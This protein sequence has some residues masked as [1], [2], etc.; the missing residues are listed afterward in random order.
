MI[1]PNSQSTTPQCVHI[2][3]R[4]PDFDFSQVEKVWLADPFKSHFMNALSILI[5]HSERIV[6]EI[7]RNNL[8]R[9]SDPVL[10]DQVSALIKQEG[11]HAAMHRKSNARLMECYPAISF[12]EKTQ[13]TFMGLVRRFSSSAF[14]LAIPAAFEHFTAAISR[15]VLKNHKKWTSGKSNQSIDFVNWHSLE[16]IEHQAVCYDVYKAMHNSGWRLVL[17]LLCFWMPITV[18]ST[19]GIQLYLLHKDRV[20]YK[21]KNWLPYLKFVGSSIGLFTKGIFQYRHPDFQPWQPADKALYLASLARM[22]ESHE[23]DSLKVAE[24]RA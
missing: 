22:E 13:Q 4:K 20:I 7:M 19:Y 15:D 18:V 16:E 8:K 23:E 14:E 5:P 11:A 10:K 9:I 17:I 24:P 6:N 3:S 21:P 12:F 2:T 1:K